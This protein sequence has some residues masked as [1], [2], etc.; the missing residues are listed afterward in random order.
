MNEW[1]KRYEY[2]I[3]N[4]KSIVPENQGVYRLIYH[5]D[6]KYYV[7]YVGESKNLQGRLNEH[8]MSS[9]PD[10]CIKK[11]LG[12]YTCYFRYIETKS[13]QDRKLIEEEQIDKFRPKCNG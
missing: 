7:F 2:N 4:V 8:L 1:T 13:E 6:G 12:Q 5:F 10:S 9:E 3:Q 11:Y